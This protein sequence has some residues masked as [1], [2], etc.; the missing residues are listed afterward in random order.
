MVMAGA[1]DLVDG[2]APPSVAGAHPHQA[3]PAAM[4]RLVRAGEGA[5]RVD[6]EDPPVGQRER[7]RRDEAGD[8]VAVLT[9]GS[10]LAISPYPGGVV[11]EVDDGNR[12][13]HV[14]AGPAA[15]AVHDRAVRA[16][17]VP[18]SEEH[19]SELQSHV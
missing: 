13:G 16:L 3:E 7:G 2:G 17:P 6:L 12:L 8:V 1:G 11:A 9:V 10:R 4:E 15:V 5:L 14:S 19:T 18:R